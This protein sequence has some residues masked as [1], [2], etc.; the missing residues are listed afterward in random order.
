MKTDE[1]AGDEGQ[2][3]AQAI[4]RGGLPKDSKRGNKKVA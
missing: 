2:T 4:R 1:G 3:L